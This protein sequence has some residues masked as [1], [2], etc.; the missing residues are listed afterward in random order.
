MTGGRCAVSRRAT[1]SLWLWG[2]GI[3]SGIISWLESKVI[4]RYTNITLCYGTL[5]DLGPNQQEVHR[6]NSIKKVP[7]GA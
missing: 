1:C 7:V 6:I 2:G 3:W 4:N 5:F